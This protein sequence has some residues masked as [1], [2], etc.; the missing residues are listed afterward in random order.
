MKR[1]KILR[2][3]CKNMNLTEDQISIALFNMNRYGG[4]FVKSLTV[5]YRKADPENKYK[6][7]RTYYWT[8]FK[9]ANFTNA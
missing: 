2:G 9:Y 5:C 1:S 3:V 4:G 6:L 7:L 8:F